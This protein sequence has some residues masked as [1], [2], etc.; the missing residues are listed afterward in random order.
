MKILFLQDDFPPESQ[1]GAG[2]STYELAIGMRKAG[3]EVVVITTTEQKGKVGESMLDG[4]RV[5]RI[6]SSYRNVWRAYRSLNNRPVV[7]AVETILERESPDVVHINNVH[8]HLSYRCFKVAKKYS[9]VVFTARDVMSFNYGKLQTKRYLQALDGTTTW[10]DHLAQAGKRW[11][12]LRNI[13]I[14]RYVQR[15]DVVVAVSEALKRV[16]HENNVRC[17]T[18]VHTGLDVAGREV[19]HEGTEEFRKKFGLRDKKVI[20]FGGR[21]SES[22]GGEQA[23]EALRLVRARV[24][25]AV[26][27]VVGTVD[28]YAERMQK[29]A[30]KIGLEDALV[31]A[32]KVPFEDMRCAYAVADVVLV[33]SICFDSLPRVVLEG[34]AAGKPVVATKYG[35]APEAV[36]DGV[37]GY[38][39]N[40]LV[41]QEIAEK[42][43]DI[44][45]TNIDVVSMGAEAKKRV[46]SEFNLAKMVREYET[47]Y[48]K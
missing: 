31:F 6:Y 12:P 17:D 41:P 46:E 36:I 20:L 15:A 22:K 2:F 16:L 13:L 37:T 19:S 48:A 9:R 3:H 18:V 29:Q 11:N 45:E 32:G 47:L 43:S 40:P 24:P 4:L 1:G 39:V 38:I 10:R 34:M 44:L 14:R 28:F 42:V 7:R 33:P 8:Y 35:G 5:F 25:S 27:L 26:L 23:L 21:L 30:S